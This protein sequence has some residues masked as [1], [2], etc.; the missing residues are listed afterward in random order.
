MRK[1]IKEDMHIHTTASDGEYSPV[2]MYEKVKDTKQIKTFAITDHDTVV[3]AKE[4]LK[5]LFKYPDDEINYIPGIEITASVFPQKFKIEKQRLHILGYEFDLNSELINEISSKRKEI[6]FL[7][8]EK[9]LYELRKLFGISFKESEI[10]KIYKKNNFGRVDIAK[11]LLYNGYVSSINEA[12]DKYLITTHEIVRDTL[13]KIYDSEV[14]EAIKKSGGY[15]SLAH[16]TSLRLKSEQL[17]EYIKYLKQM[18]LDSIEVYHSHH[19]RSF[20][21]ELLNITKE[22]ELL[23]SGGSDYHGPVIKPKIQLGL[24]KGSGKVKELTLA[25]HILERRNNLRKEQ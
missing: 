3:G 17:N 5:Y 25:H 8:V 2:K 24:E 21:K 4:V 12:F 1:L 20:S 22:Q 6:D 16:A 7:A 15:V 10:E 9:Q 19:K 23:I 13:P 11:L 14:I 18:G